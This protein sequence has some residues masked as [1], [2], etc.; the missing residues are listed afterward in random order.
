ARA[1]AQSPPRGGGEPERPPH[2]TE[3]ARTEGPPHDGV[4]VGQRAA[5]QCQ[6]AH[7]HL[8]IA[9]KSRP[10]WAGRRVNMSRVDSIPVQSKIVK[11]T[12]R[13]GAPSAP[14]IRS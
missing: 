12:A 11:A 7:L 2:R 8:S 13:Q 10:T 5:P 4:E 1:R 6:T 3:R 9:K 14:A